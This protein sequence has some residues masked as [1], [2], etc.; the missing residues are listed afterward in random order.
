MA[1]SAGDPVYV[2]SNVVIYV[3]EDDPRFGPAAR[4][5]LADCADG[6]YNAFISAAVCAEVLTGPYRRG[7]AHAVETAR[8]LLNNDDLFLVLDHTRKDF[9]ASARLRGQSGLD[10]ADSLHVA[11]ATNNGCRALVTNDR[12]LVSGGDPLVV[13]LAS[14][15][16]GSP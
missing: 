13:P 12:K 15:S 1:L 11:T 8:D 16:A 2:D 3:L 7:D 5:F 10:F 14:L 4:S 6:T 9:E